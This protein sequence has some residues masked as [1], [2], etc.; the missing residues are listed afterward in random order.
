MSPAWLSCAT[1]SPSGRDSGNTC[2]RSAGFRSTSRGSSAA[3]RSWT[4]LERRHRRGTIAFLPMPPVTQALIIV[5]V[6][7]LLLPATD[8]PLIEWFALWPASSGLEAGAGFEPWQLI[9]YSFLH[10]GVTHIL[11]NMFALYMF[12]GDIERL[13]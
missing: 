12:G 2:A 4:P 10:G 1:A 7:V 5:N 8:L 6:A 3:T 13:V 9:S 11:F